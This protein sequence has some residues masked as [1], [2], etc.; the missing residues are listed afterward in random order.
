MIYLPTGIA[1]TN[2][3]MALVADRLSRYLEHPVI[4]KTGISG[5]FDFKFQNEGYDSNA[6]FTHDDVI[7]SI[8]TSVREIGLELTPANGPIETIVIDHVEKPTSN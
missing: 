2:A 3:S 5:S 8:L 6:D 7:S 4:D 1:G